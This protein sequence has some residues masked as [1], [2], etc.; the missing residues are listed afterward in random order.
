MEKGKKFYKIKKGWP[1]EITYTERQNSKK[2]DGKD[3]D[4]WE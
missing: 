1:V 4:R 2:E 3:H